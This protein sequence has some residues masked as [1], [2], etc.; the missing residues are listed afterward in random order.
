MD[1]SICGIRVV[2]VNR[3]PIIASALAALVDADPNFQVVAKASCCAEC[4]GSIASTDPDLIICDLQSEEAAGPSSFARLRNCLPDVPAIVLTEDDHEQR[5]LKIVRSGVQGLLTSNAL[6]TTLFAAARAVARGS[7]Y[8]EEC[9]QSKLMSLIRGSNLTN[10]DKGLLNSRE[11]TI[12][13][14]IANGLTNE[15]IGNAVCLSKSAVKYH[16]KAIFRK[17]GVSNRAE[18]VRIAADQRLLD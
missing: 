12:L 3:S 13:R 7:Y 17:L 1:E 8:F 14:L 11:Y 10:L 16:N 6:P 4:C 9:I 15:Q 2:I 5:I 18:A